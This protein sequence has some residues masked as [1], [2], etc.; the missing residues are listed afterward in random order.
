MKKSQWGMVAGLAASVSMVA[1]CNLSK[2]V[3]QVAPEGTIGSGNQAGVKPGNTTGGNLGNN[4]NTGTMTQVGDATIRGKVLDKDGNPVA[5]ATV[6]SGSSKTITAADGS[7][8]LK[9]VSGEAVNIKVLKDGYVLRDSILPVAKGEMLEINS[10]LVKAD[11][12]VTPINAAAGG[13][14]VSSDGKTELIF[15]PG[16]LK[17][18]ADVRVTWLN[19]VESASRPAAFKIAAVADAG[20]VGGSADE[21][22]AAVT[23]VPA[24]TA[25][26]TTDLPGPLETKAYG[27]RKFFSPVS[28]AAITM[29]NSLKEGESATLRM[30]ISDEVLAD[31]RK[32]G[33]L[34]DSDLGQDI[35]PCFSWSADESTWDKPALSKVVKDEKGKYWF[36]YTVRASSLS[37][38]VASYQ[39]LQ[40]G[41]TQGSARVELQVG[42][43][44]QVVDGTFTYGALV[45]RSSSPAYDFKGINATMSSGQ[46][47]SP[48]VSNLIRPNV[49]TTNY[50]GTIYGPVM[51]VD[52][53]G[54]W[55]REGMFRL[56]FP[57][58]AQY[59]ITGPKAY[60]I[61]PADNARTGTTARAAQAY[62]LPDPTRN[63]VQ[64]QSIQATYVKPFYYYTDGTV[65]VTLDGVSSESANASYKF[66]YTV[67]NAAKSAD[68][69]ASNNKISFK[70]PRNAAGSAQKF[71]VKSIVGTSFSSGDGQTPSGNLPVGGSLA[72]TVKMFANGAK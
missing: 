20:P 47:H 18:D 68:V 61:F 36:E 53:F 65:T 15:A 38:A 46:Y 34:K 30:E 42:G 26:N 19:P 41:D 2:P 32:N 71:Q 35:F 52:E 66:N 31:M 63:A 4:A 16:A 72:L 64:T 24:V 14:A 8:T 60:G 1:A 44:R 43:G 17:G 54:K 21:T 69:T 33:D 9:I 10:S 37:P 50:T 67:D 28:F 45:E 25:L 39:T 3:S 51:G 56:A 11:K 48:S 59:Q 5:G 57:P 13:K 62:L 29:S 27:D 6:M 7:Y 12:N 70:L 58:G 23:P 40:V 49:A 55:D 22:P